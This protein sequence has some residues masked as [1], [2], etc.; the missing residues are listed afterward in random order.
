MDGQNVVTPGG[1]CEYEGRKI[2]QGAVTEEKGKFVKICSKGRVKSKLA[3]KVPTPYPLVGR[4]TG[5]GKG[6]IMI[7]LLEGALDPPFHL[8]IKN[9]Y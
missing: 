1:D 6:K 2:C 8:K 5:P 3:R 7:A 4:D 9:P